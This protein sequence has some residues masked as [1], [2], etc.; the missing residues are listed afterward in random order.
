MPQHWPNASPF[1]KHPLIRSHNPDEI[2]AFLHAR[3][4]ELDLAAKDARRFDAC[5]DGV[6]LPDTYITYV[7]YN[8]PVSIRTT[9]AN[10]DHWMLLPINEYFEAASENHVTVCGPTAAMSYRQVGTVFCD[11]KP[12]ALGYRC[13]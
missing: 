13:A 2:R 3:G 4:I 7:D 12:E 9:E 11:H 8:A 6:G 10:C 1:P 5:L